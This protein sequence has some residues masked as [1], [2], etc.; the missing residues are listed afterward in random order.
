MQLLKSWQQFLAY[1]C[2][3]R[4]KILSEVTVWGEGSV[5]GKGQFVGECNSRDTKEYPLKLDV[6]YFPRFTLYLGISHFDMEQGNDKHV[7]KSSKGYVYSQICTFN[8]AKVKLCIC[9]FNKLH[10]HSSKR[11]GTAFISLAAIIYHYT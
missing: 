4:R 6:Q 10:D 8:L 5:A 7:N 3:N 9:P 2:H 1:S 11:T